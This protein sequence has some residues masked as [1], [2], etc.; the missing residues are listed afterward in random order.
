M[1]TLPE[2]DTV[3]MLRKSLMPSMGFATWSERDEVCR[4]DE[5]GD[6]RKAQ[7]AQWTKQKKN[8]KKKQSPSLF[9][10]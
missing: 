7:N 4:G 8:N 1:A 5:E 9:L 3:A 6:R 10:A 2:V